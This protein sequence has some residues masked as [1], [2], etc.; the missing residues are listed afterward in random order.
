MSHLNFPFKK[1]QG[2][3]NHFILVD[4]RDRKFDLS[5]EFATKLCDVH[6]GVGA[7]GLITVE[8]SD[9]A[10]FKMR[11]IN[12]DGSEPEM[13]GNGIRCFAQFVFE[14]GLCD[15]RELEIETLAG[16]VATERFKRENLN[17]V[18]VDMGEP[19]FSKDGLSENIEDSRAIKIEGEE[20]FYVSMGNP[21]AIRFVE[22]FQF[23]Y[24]REGAFVENHVS[25]FPHRTNVEFVRLVNSRELELRVWER[26]CGETYACG[27]GAC[28]SVVAGI[29]KGLLDGKEIRVRLIGGTLYIRWQQ[30]GH[31]IMTGPAQSV[32]RGEFLDESDL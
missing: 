26:G 4:N 21:H 3:G 27:T 29:S 32:Y 25:V 14:E 28:A 5:K 11:V 18:K 30:D 19:V 24:K 16:L 13:C 10:D 12:A 17:M 8:N 6:Y 7:D 31:V 2:L 20:Y 15:K 9:R 1:M 23:D 22:D